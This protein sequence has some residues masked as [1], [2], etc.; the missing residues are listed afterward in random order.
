VHRLD[1][2]YDLAPAVRVSKMAGLVAVPAVAAM[3]MRKNG[4]TAGRSRGGEALV[5]VGMLAESV[6][7]LDD[8]GRFALRLPALHVD[9]VAVGCGKSLLVM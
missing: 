1:V 6:H 7:N 9:V 8:G 2:R 4:I 3:V 5:T